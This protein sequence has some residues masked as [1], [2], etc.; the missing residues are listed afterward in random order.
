MG[1]EYSNIF[2]FGYGILCLC[3]L[4]A[5]LRAKSGESTVVTTKEFQIFQTGFVTGYGG[6]ILGELIA[7]ACFY[8]VFISL[9]LS[10][11][12]ITKLYLATVISSTITNVGLEIF[13]LGTR[14]SKCLLSS[15]LYAVAMGSIFM[16]SHY[17]L[18][19]MGR[20][21]YG[22]AQALQHSA[23]ESYAV[24]QH[25]SNGFP[26]DWLAQTFTYL[27]HIMS[28]LA[29]LSGF[30]AE[31]V[32]AWG[33]AGCVFL[34]LACFALSSLYIA[35]VWEK[36]INTPKFM[37]T[38][39]LFNLS[40]SVTAV[41]TNKVLWYVLTVSALYETAM[42]VFAYYWAPWLTELLLQAQPD[43][44]IPYEIV[45]AGLM[46][47]SMLAN[48]LATTYSLHLDQLFQTSMITTT[49][50]FVL[51]AGL[52]HPALA[53]ALALAIQASL[54]VYYP[55]MGYFRGKVI[56]PELRNTTLL[57]PK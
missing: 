36:D 42:L 35:I 20:V 41:R 27:T 3:L 45:F 5:Y 30:F 43:V 53:Y 11:Y 19:V 15:V 57:L 38:G 16:G 23:F 1:D 7:S 14:K 13:D 10:L 25:A 55:A 29:V 32:S 44:S 39:F 12:H 47:V 17:E 24:A 49:V 34:A 33:M 9:D 21:I 22:V 31:M 48:Y 56:L 40:S 51:A 8:H 46:M 2:Y 50:F 37:L 28:L 4:I 52:A 26:D 18:L 6:V 54:G